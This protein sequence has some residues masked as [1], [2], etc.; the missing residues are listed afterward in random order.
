MSSHQGRVSLLVPVIT[1]LLSSVAPLSSSRGEGR[2]A[3]VVQEV[4]EGRRSSVLDRVLYEESSPPVTS[5]T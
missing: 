4:A 5:R 2:A 3:E 1:T